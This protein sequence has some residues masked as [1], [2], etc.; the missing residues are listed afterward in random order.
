MNGTHFERAMA[1]A[2]DALEHKGYDNI[3]TKDVML[4]GFKYLAEKQQEHS[5]LRLRVDGKAWFSAAL[6]IG[7]LLGGLVQT[8]L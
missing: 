3:N 2:E 5:V 1:Q 7:G 6:L 4:V 8:F